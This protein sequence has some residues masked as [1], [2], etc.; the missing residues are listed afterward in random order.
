MKLFFIFGTLVLWY[1]AINNRI[2][3][4]KF[5]EWKLKKN[6]GVIVQK[7]INIQP[8]AQFQSKTLQVLYIDQHPGFYLAKNSW[9]DIIGFLLFQY[10]AYMIRSDIF[11]T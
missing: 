3:A 9:Y 10:P 7:K 11:V 2:G 4:V 5:W 6:R 1:V 8:V